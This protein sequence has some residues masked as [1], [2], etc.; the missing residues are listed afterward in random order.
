MSSD[1]LPLS[2]VAAGVAARAIERLRTANAIPS[3]PLA[4]LENVLGASE[5][6]ASAL[7]GDPQ[8]VAAPDRLET[9]PF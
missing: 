2:A 6:L 5:F 4:L 7:L 9:A 8:L 1:E 3:A